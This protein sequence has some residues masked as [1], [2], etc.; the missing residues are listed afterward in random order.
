MSKQQC[1]G[2]S[3]DF[4]FNGVSCSQGT[5][6]SD[7]TTLLACDELDGNFLD[8]A[9][10]V[11]VLHMVKCLGAQNFAYN[12]GPAIATSNYCPPFIKLV[13]EQQI[14]IEEESRGDMAIVV[15]KGKPSLK[16]FCKVADQS[17][18]QCMTAFME[19]AWTA[20]EHTSMFDGRSYATKKE[21][22]RDS[23]LNT[24]AKKMDDIIKE[25]L[26]NAAPVDPSVDIFIAK[27]QEVIADMLTAMDAAYP[28][29]VKGELF[30]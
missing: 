7:L 29:D 26:P 27:K 11:F 10:L 23:L 18:S 5:D 4:R 9:R 21:Q 15:V 1:L 2:L 22:F 30:F 28:D 14:A 3:R 13:V 20:H 12:G 17:V 16:H 24:R 25:V 19:I 8:R 6:K